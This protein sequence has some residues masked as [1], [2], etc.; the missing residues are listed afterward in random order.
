MSEVSIPEEA[1]ERMVPLLT[2]V[3]TEGD[4]EDAAWD[5]ARAAA[6][7]IVASELARL[8]D[9]LDQRASR[10]QAVGGDD[11]EPC[12]DECEESTCHTVAAVA[13]YLRTSGI[14][15]RRASVLRGEGQKDG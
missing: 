2:H 4:A 5:L 3:L 8:A 6:P 13:T 11:E 10:R 12:E 14:L 1:I 15:R 9:E 7:M